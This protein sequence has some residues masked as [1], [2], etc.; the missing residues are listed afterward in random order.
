MTTPLIILCFLAAFWGI[1]SWKRGSYA[2]FGT[3]MTYVDGFLVKDQP[4]KDTVAQRLKDLQRNIIV[5]LEYAE[6]S[7]GDF[8]CDACV[9]RIRQ[10]WSGT[11]SEIKSTKDN[12]AY[13]ENKR[14]VHVCI[15]QP[16]GIGLDSENTCMYTLLHEL[17][18]I[19]TDEWGHTDT[20]W[21]NFK[22]LLELAVKAGVYKYSTYTDDT[23]YCGHFVGRSPLTCVQTQSCTSEMSERRCTLKQ[24]TTTKK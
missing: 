13:T 16:D 2:A 9:R 1:V 6:S 18:H 19:C 14:N 4:G 20:F 22:F 17:A 12:I 15:Q 3:G 21:D 10:R 7:P 11:V 23:T 5:L 24:A 8:S